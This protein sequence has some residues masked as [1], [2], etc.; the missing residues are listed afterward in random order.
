M[1][2]SPLA[3]PTEEFRRK[4]RTLAGNI[5]IVRALPGLLSGSARP[6]FDFVSHKVVR[7]ALPWAVLL[8]GLSSLWLPSPARSVMLAAQAVCYALAA[9]DVVIPPA[10]RMKRVSA[11]PR[12]FVVLLVAAACATPLALVGRGA[13]WRPSNIGTGRPAPTRADRLPH[14]VPVIR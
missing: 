9:L 13:Q 12:T 2:S 10:S 11:A 6:R 7:L 4:V 5:Q 14:T 1:T 3:T 8:V